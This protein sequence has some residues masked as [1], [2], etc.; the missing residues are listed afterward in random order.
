MIKD[1]KLKTEMV[2]R[3]KKQ[4]KI[5]REIKRSRRRCKGE[6][7]KKLPNWR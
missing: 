7:R 6:R 3:R 2:R 4:I 5:K 1:K